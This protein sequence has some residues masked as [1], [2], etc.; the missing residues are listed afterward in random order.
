MGPREKLIEIIRLTN[1]LP[2][3][4]GFFI[5]FFNGSTDEREKRVK[6]CN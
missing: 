4:D 1:H 5:E 3:S 6:F 2:K